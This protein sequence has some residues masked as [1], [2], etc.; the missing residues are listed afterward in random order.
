MT[1]YEITKI[2]STHGRDLKL[3]YSETLKE[4][5]HLV[6]LGADGRIILKRLLEKWDMRTS[7]VLL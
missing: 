5:Y 7:G 1:E 4:K 6:D 2:R 3:F